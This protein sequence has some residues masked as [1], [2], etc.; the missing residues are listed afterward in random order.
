MSFVVY[1]YQ[2]YKKVIKDR[3]KDLKRTKA[4]FTLQ[5]LADVL[6]IQYTFLSKVMNSP[7]H[8]LNED[9]VFTV[10]YALEFLDDEV[11]YLLLLRSYQA[12]GNRTRKDF[13]FQR[14]SS[15]QKQ[16]HLSLNTVKT[17]PSAFMED[18][19][20][21]MD[22]RVV[23][24]HTALSIKQIQKTPSL[25]CPI[26]GIDIAHLKQILVLL[27]RT[28]RIKLDMKSGEVLEILHPRIHFGKD[29]PLTRTHQLIMKSALN[30]MSFTKSEEKKENLFV[31]FTMDAEGFEKIRKRIKEFTT[32]VQKI[33]MDSKD[34]GVYQLNLDFVEVF[35]MEK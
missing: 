9:Q 2:D 22:Y 21:L 27:D 28:G 30:Q 20:Y 13:L 8:Q 18:M 5:Y 31:T 32:D 14:I 25:L 19:T 17:A 12:T 35:G 6:G 1:E 15:L 23:I 3:L 26:L 4:K 34:S 33:A 10:S 29:H 11:E 7:D 24:A 16:H